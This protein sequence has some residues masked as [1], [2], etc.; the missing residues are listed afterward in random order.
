MA[1]FTINYDSFFIISVCFIFTIT[2][3]NF[4]HNILYIYVPK[5]RRTLMSKF[6]LET[7]AI[8]AIYPYSIA[9]TTFPK[10]LLYTALT[11]LP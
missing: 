5:A 10:N 2:H 11:H 1:I 4:Y 6:H 9:I 8:T 7:T 3:G